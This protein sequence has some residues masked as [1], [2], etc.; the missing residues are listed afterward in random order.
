MTHLLHLD[1]SARR[2][3]FSRELGAEYASRWRTAH[4]SGVYTYRDLAADPVPVITEGWTELCDELLRA[5]ITDPAR[6]PEAVRTDAQ[7]AAWEVCRPLL[8]ELLAADTVLITTP[9]YNFTIPAALKLWIDQVT[10]PRM[11]LTGKRFVIASAR[12]GSYRPGTPRASVEH[13]E[14]YLRAFLSGHYGVTN[15]VFITTELTNT[16]VDPT[17]AHLSQ[18]HEASHRAALTAAAK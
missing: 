3:S 14:T 18:A 2:R 7:K 1:T 15:P 11:S 17:L 8:D 5:G 10:F 4:P 12:G 16:Q 9:M 13:Q 6:Y